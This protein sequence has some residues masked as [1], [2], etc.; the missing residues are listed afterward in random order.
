MAA[1]PVNQSSR[2]DT[3]WTTVNATEA[4]PGRTTPLTWTF[5]TDATEL[6]L[7]G[8]FAEM[9]VL[10]KREVE[11]PADG[12]ERFV[13]IFFAHPAANLNRFRL[14]AD[15]SPGS[16]GD[17][18]ERQF[19]GT[20]RT[21]AAS[22][23]TR[24]RY[25][26]VAARMPVALARVSR[27]VHRIRD[28]THAWWRD[29]VQGDPEPNRDRRLL[30]EAVEQYRRVLHWHG[31]GSMLTQG[32]YDQ[33]AQTCAAAGLKGQEN[34]IVGGLEGLDEAEVVG[35]LWELSRGRLERQAVLAKH[36]FHGPEEGELATTVWRERPELLDGVIAALAAMPDQ[37]SPERKCE[38]S[39]TEARRAA[40]ELRAALGLAARGRARM[41][42]ALARKLMPLREVGRGAMV[43]TF[44]VGRCAARRLGES[45]VAR[46]ALGEV[47]DVFFLTVGELTAAEL[48]ADARELVAERRSRHE[49]YL[50]LNLPDGWWGEPEP[51]AEPAA[52]LDAVELE[53]VGASPGAVAGVARVVASS[54]GSDDLN[55]GEVLV[56]H[57]TDPGWAPLMHACSALVID[58]G[59]P[60]SH[61]AIVARELGVPCVIGT[62]NGSRMIRDGE[63]I[64]VDGTTG[65]VRFPDRVA[66]LR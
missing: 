21:G 23:K 37:E 31:L 45:L 42:T 4:L 41:L 57:T 14:A 40:A 22:Q 49:R 55:P 54:Q 35:D 63:R 46:G 29:A 25:P 28:E 15:L 17:A 47:D 51:I 52:D 36:G 32:I 8:S 44:D 30:A 48:P 20:V 66:A 33:V 56:C 16:S 18:L 2:E 64:E 38:R 13:G 24:R 65:L 3:Y 7:R 19:F 5:Y 43:R 10:S 11:L 53:G 27:R 1:D 9:G 6:G 59:G 50:E 62:G 12:D 34:A 26:V 58:V 60:L 61:G 39:A